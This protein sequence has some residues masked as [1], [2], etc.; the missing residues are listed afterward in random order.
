[1]PRVAL[2]K[3]QKERN[4]V[5]DVCKSIL[6]GLNIKRGLS[7]KNHEA[8]CQ[9]IGISYTTWWRWNNGGIADA[10][11][12]NVIAAAVRAGIEVKVEVFKQ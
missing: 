12:G 7:R 2:T 11:F 5:A 9:M 10:E 6:D 3:E 1:M 8:F 4:A